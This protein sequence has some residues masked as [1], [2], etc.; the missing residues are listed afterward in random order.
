MQA[1]SMVVGPVVFSGADALFRTLQG[2]SYTKETNRHNLKMEQLET[3]R[4]KWDRDYALEQREY[5]R[6]RILK[7]DATVTQMEDRATLDRLLEQKDQIKG[8]LRLENDRHRKQ[9]PYYNTIDIVVTSGA[10]FLGYKIC[11]RYLGRTTLGE[12]SSDI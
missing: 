5:D 6:R 7:E 8:Q 1:L 11:R 9:N 3:S 12:P 4:I 10:V 2:D